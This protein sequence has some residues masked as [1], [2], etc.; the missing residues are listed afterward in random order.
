MVIEQTVD[1]SLMVRC[2]DGSLW[3]P[4]RPRTGSSGNNNDCAVAYFGQDH[5]DGLLVWDNPCGYNHQ[6]LCEKPV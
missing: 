3:A 4:G 5:L 2:D 6:A 1:G